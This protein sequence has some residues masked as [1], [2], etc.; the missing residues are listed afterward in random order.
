MNY[1]NVFKCCS[2]NKEYFNENEFLCENAIT[3]KKYNFHYSIMAI[4]R[5]KCREFINKQ[6]DINYPYV[7]L[8]D[9]DINID[10]AI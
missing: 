3:D 9:T 7:L 10:M 6:D 5:N 4:A 1:Y 2:K 8:I